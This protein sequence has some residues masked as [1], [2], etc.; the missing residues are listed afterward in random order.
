MGNLMRQEEHRRRLVRWVAVHVMPHEPAVRAW[1]RRAVIQEGDVDDIIQE[2][3][4][5][6]SSLEAF[7]SILNPS[8]YFFAI[9][10]NILTDH[11]RRTRVVRFEAI[12][13]PG[14][15]EFSTE[16]SGQEV[17]LD[18]KREL[19]MVQQLIEGLPSRCREVFLL[20]KVLGLSQR[21]I[22]AKLGISESAVE[23]EGVRGMRLILQGLRDSGF[24]PSYGGKASRG[25]RGKRKERHAKP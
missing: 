6:L 16:D 4:C 7:D 11:L 17:A 3:Y 10:R 22:A 19:A 2:A 20:R 23:N 24:E 5:K 1:L 25:R 13:G 12:S 15:L 18:A 8:G 14:A 9:S 21:E